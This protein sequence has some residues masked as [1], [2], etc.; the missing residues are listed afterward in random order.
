MNIKVN[1][2][3]RTASCR[4]GG[5]TVEC[6]GKPVRISVCHCLDC[7]K[8][9]GSAFAV[10]A[11]WPDAKVKLNGAYKSWQ[12]TADSGHRAT[13]KFCPV[14]GSTLTYI[15]EG[16]DGVTAVPVGAFA[17]QNFPDPGFS[18]YENRK[19]GWVDILGGEVK[20]SS[21]PSSKRLPGRDIHK[22]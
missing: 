10:Q 15:I 4:C 1:E 11:R 18:V 5:L 21:M 8:R 3:R 17:D 12:R 13:Y 16:W 14:C 7:Q 19:H 2:I 9:S 22:T 6:I 20:H